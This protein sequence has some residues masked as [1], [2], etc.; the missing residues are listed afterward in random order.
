MGVDMLESAVLEFAELTCNLP[1]QELE[2]EWV[3]QDYDEGVRFAF[4]RNYEDLCTLA[5][6]LE[7]GRS[8]PFSEA[9]CILAQYHL[10]YR[11]LQA[12]LLGID[13]DLAMQEPAEGEWPL[14]N[15]LVHIIQAEGTFFAIVYY[16]LERQRSGDDRPLEM[17][18][19]AWEAFWAGD[20]FAEIKEKR[21]LSELLTYYNQLHNRVL[22]AFNGISSSELELP[23]VFWESTPMPVRFRLHRFDSHMRQHTIQV[24]KTLDMLGRRPNEARRLLR[25]IYN[26]LAKVEAARL[27]DGEIGEKEYQALAAQITVRTS[28]IRLVLSNN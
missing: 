21:N 13:D 22:K 25:L 20:P 4:F 7:A 3:W 9:R 10:A 6:R 15:V 23:V 12:L 24:Q 26:A 11:D 2:R 27:G 18:D 28:E 16:T 14:S 1:D 5:A 19:E 8:A 17:P